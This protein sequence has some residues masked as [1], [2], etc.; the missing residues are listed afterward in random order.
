MLD[1]ICIISSQINSQFKLYHKIKNN[2]GHKKGLRPEVKKERLEMEKVSFVWILE[3][4][5]KKYRKSIHKELK[6]NNS[7]FFPKIKYH[8]CF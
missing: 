2:L 8:N 6:E 3:K 1:C 4:L 5:G 7:F